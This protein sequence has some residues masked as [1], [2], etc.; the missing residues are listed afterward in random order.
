MFILDSGK[1][2]DLLRIWNRHQHKYILELMKIGYQI[3]P[4]N[5][6]D[7]RGKGEK[8]FN[9]FINKN[10]SKNGK[11]ERNKINGFM[12]V[13]VPECTKKFPATSNR[14]SKVLILPVSLQDE[15]SV[16]GV[17]SIIEEVS[18]ILG[19]P[20]P[21]QEIYLLFDPVKLSFD[22]EDARNKFIFLK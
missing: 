21:E 7:L 14:K 3:V 19:I 18:Q 15:S 1:H 11:P 6:K 4:E 13:R 8:A 22:I 17:A 10:F 12:E 20:M 2:S 16:T 5:F 9:T